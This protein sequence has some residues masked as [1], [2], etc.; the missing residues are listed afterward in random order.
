MSYEQAT[1]TLQRAGDTWNK[2]RGTYV[3]LPRACMSLKIFRVG[4][5]LLPRA[6][7]TLNILRGRYVLLPLAGS[8]LNIFQGRYVIAFEKAEVL[9]LRTVALRKIVI[10][11]LG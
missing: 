4:Y 7:S 5:V 11:R 2:F 9:L 6:G 1:P 8:T 3:L 10:D